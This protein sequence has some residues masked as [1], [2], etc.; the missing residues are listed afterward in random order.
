MSFFYFSTAVVVS[1]VLWAFLWLLFGAWSIPL[2]I[3]L[4]SALWWDAYH[5]GKHHD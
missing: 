1:L 4:T 5:V 2:L 3:V